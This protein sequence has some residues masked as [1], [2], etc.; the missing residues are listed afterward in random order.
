LR[1]GTQ[2]CQCCCVVPDMMS[3]SP[4]ASGTVILC[5]LQAQA[6]QRH[7]AHG[8]TRLNTNRHTAVCSRLPASIAACCCCQLLPA[9][10]KIMLH[11]RPY[12]S[13]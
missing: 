10:A 2:C 5:V 4:E 9:A 6:S 13:H 1:L 7:A 3:T 11:L 12:L 8:N